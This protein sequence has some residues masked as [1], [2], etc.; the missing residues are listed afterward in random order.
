MVQRQLIVI[1]VTV[2]TAIEAI[3][4]L[5]KQLEDLSDHQIE[6]PGCSSMHRAFST[7]R[8]RPIPCRAS[9]LPPPMLGL[10]TVPGSVQCR[11]RSPVLPAIPTPPTHACWSLRRSMPVPEAPVATIYHYAGGACSC[12]F[13]TYDAETPSMR[14]LLALP[15][16]LPDM[17]EDLQR[18]SLSLEIWR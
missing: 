6:Y 1:T 8:T 17:P 13:N 16:D 3:P 5:K 4:V 9:P 11:H 12:R 10:G 2:N 7:G 15:K 18:F 14:K